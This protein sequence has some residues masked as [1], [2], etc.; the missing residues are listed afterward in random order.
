M[1]KDKSAYNSTKTVV[2]VTTNALIAEKLRKIQHKI[3]N[4]LVAGVQNINIELQTDKEF[5]KD[6]DRFT[7]YISQK[8]VKLVILFSFGAIIKKWAL[9]LVPMLNVHFSL[10]P[11]YRG[12]VPVIASILNGD[13]ETGITIHKVEPEI[14]AGDILLQVKY[15][16]AENDTA[17][18]AFEAL[19]NISINMLENMLLGQ[20]IDKGIVFENLEFLYVPG[21][22]GVSGA[23]GTSGASGAQDNSNNSSFGHDIRQNSGQNALNLDVLLDLDKYSILFKQ[24][25]GVVSYA[26]FSLMDTKNSFV[27][28]KRLTAREISNRVRAFYDNPLA[29][30]Y[31]NFIDQRRLFLLHKVEPISCQVSRNISSNQTHYIDNIQN[32]FCEQLRRLQPGQV[33]FSKTHGLLVKTLLGAIKI[34]QGGLENKKILKDKELL[35]LKGKLREFL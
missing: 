15:R 33:L 30:G 11:Q 1:L 27:S 10:L 5:F 34:V 18:S 4:D 8:N 14:D 31:V 19:T 29:R 12:A 24:Q 21:G 16:Y 28:F 6:K 23:F 2:F 9:E 17:K 7:N 35:S 32:Q 3:N 22:A 20:N 25:A 13:N 26:P